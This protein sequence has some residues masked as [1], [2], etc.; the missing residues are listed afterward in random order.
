MLP[1]STLL[2]LL[3]II[4]ARRAFAQLKP[5]TPGPNETYTA[6]S[7]CNISWA[8]DTSGT[9]KNVTIDLMSGS[10]NNMSLVKNVASAL[11]GTDKSLTP[12]S[13]K[14]PEV[15][16]YSAIYFYQFTNGDDIST[17]TW[18]TRFTIA[19]S[20]NKTVAPENPSQP[21]GDSIPWGIGHIKEVESSNSTSSTDNE[22]ASPTTPASASPSATMVSYR[23][24]PHGHKGDSDDQSESSGDVGEED[25]SD[26]SDHDSTSKTQPANVAGAKSSAA[27][28]TAIAHT[29]DSSSGN[30]SDADGDDGDDSSDDSSRDKKHSYDSGETD[31]AEQPMR[32][33]AP[34]YKDSGAADAADSTNSANGRCGHLADSKNHA[35]GRNLLSGIRSLMAASVFSALALTRL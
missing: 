30:N 3:I 22:I 14:C 11:D 29:H 32:D 12:Y 5:T 18:T 26:D 34:Q 8:V 7:S 17:R 16:P 15:D 20:S 9:W 6:G 13:W 23:K 25:G 27:R 31:Q 24:K 28:A 2:Q 19:S 21:N 1:P 4:T 33:P 10:N 35:G